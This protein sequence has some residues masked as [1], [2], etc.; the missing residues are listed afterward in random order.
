MGTP[1]VKAWIALGAGVLTAAVCGASFAAAASD[2]SATTSASAGLPKQCP[3]HSMVAKTLGLTLRTSIVTY[4]SATYQGGGA[5]SSRAMP[6]GPTPIQ[7]TQKTCLYTY[8]NAQQSAAEG[9]IVPVT[10]TFEFPVTK[11]NFTAARHA[12]EHS[13]TPITVRGIG[14][15]AW[16]VKAPRGDP[17]GGNSLF[18]LS[19]TT[20]VVVGGPPKATVALMGQLVRGII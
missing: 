3:S 11:A 8:P 19:G 2:H 1:P 15:V 10:I 9:I 6:A 20:E 5:S 14:D 4:T 16:V 7:A 17:R 13:V 12:A 18:V